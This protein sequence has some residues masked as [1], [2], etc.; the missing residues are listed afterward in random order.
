MF[1]LTAVV[2]LAGVMFASFGLAA[3]DSPKFVSLK[4][5][6]QVQFNPVGH[7]CNENFN[8]A[9]VSCETCYDAATSPALG[10]QTTDLHCTNNAYT[11]CDNNGNSDYY[12]PNK[13]ICY[14]EEPNA[15]C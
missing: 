8:G 4:A 9:G 15:V 1:A 6:E 14:C 2:A 10:Y 3:A 7:I 11:D 5:A 13:R 12:L